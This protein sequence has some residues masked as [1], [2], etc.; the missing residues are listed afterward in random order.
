[1]L[2]YASLFHQPVAAQKKKTELSKYEHD[3]VIC[4]YIIQ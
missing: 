4:D 3:N 2:I 1:M